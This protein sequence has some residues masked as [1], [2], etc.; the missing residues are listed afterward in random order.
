MKKD[1]YME[2]ELGSMNWYNF[3][4]K[5]IIISTLKASIRKLQTNFCTG[6]HCVQLKKSILEVVWLDNL[7][8]A[9][10]ALCRAIYAFIRG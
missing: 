9:V 7:F 10:L 8:L 3:Y 5:G 2:K 4:N 6:N 1:K